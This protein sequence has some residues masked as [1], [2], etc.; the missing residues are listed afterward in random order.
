M[1][2]KLLIPAI[3]A[4]LVLGLVLA[5]VQPWSS[6]TPPESTPE[7][8][9]SQPTDQI[10]PQPDTTNPNVSQAELPDGI[11]I[12]E[13]RKL[14]V[15]WHAHYDV[16]IYPEDSFGQSVSFRIQLD[17]TP[18]KYI[19]IQ[20]IALQD[21]NLGGIAVDM[22]GTDAEQYSVYSFSSYPTNL[23]TVSSQTTGQSSVGGT[24]SGKHLSDKH[25]NLAMTLAGIDWNHALELY[26]TMTQADSAYRQSPSAPGNLQQKNEARAAYLDYLT[27]YQQLAVELDLDAPDIHSVLLSVDLSSVPPG[28]VIEECTLTVGKDTY[29]LPLGQIRFQETPP[30]E[31]T[32]TQAHD[33]LDV[34][35]ESTVYAWD[36]GFFSTNFAF[37]AKE[38]MILDRIEVLG[39]NGTVVGGAWV[40]QID[41]S[42]WQKHY[43]PEKFTDETAKSAY[44]SSYFSRIQPT[45]W[46]NHTPFYV[47]AGDLLCIRVDFF[48]PALAQAVHYQGLTRYALHYTTAEGQGVIAL[49]AELA[50]E[51]PNAYE[52]YYTYLENLDLSSYYHFLNQGGELPE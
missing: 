49:E 45:Y 1:K 46:S 27:R 15:A 6:D 4:L 30:A 37:R 18:K 51:L 12:D 38:A 10:A 41:Q 22:H 34:Q 31:D 23:F 32:P 9:P 47:N 28:T 29:L 24:T 14:I 17:Q 13:N 43:P 19:A 33:G 2:K 42:L 35:R 40:Q 7:S 8:T 21:V 44:Q 20:L 50:A 39:G 16:D 48:S 5:L 52:L 36:D 11:L 26:T 25:M 3:I